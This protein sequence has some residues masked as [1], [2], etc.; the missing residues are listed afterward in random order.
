MPAT[1]RVTSLL[2]SGAGTLRAAIEQ[3]DR[4]PHHDT[5]TFARSLAGTI[6]LTSALPD[7]ST[8]IV[9]SGPGHS[10]LTV[11][12]SSAPGTPAFGVFA[13]SSGAR[14]AISGLTITGGM[15]R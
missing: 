8:D 7:L 9:I 2:D 5:I 11:A 13:V 14:V 12:R 4:A 3:A 15:R 10:V 6:T 1:I